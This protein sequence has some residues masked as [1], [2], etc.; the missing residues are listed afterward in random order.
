M[1][2]FCRGDC[3]RQAVQQ[4]KKKSDR[5]SAWPQRQ[6][7]KWTYQK[8]SMA[9]GLACKRSGVQS[10]RQERSGYGS[11]SREKLALSVF[12]NQWAA[13]GEI[14]N[15]ERYGQFWELSGQSEQR[16]FVFV[17]SLAV[18]ELFVVCLRDTENSPT[19][20]NCSSNS[21]KEQE[22]VVASV[23]R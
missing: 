21:A 22:L 19:G 10:G 1:F 20:D 7:R 3:S 6:D 11:Y 4:K 18:V 9:G 12:V 5:A 13:N 16:V 2:K 14:Q 15:E 23:D 8:K 17:F